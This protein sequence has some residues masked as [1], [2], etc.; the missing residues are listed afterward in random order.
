MQQSGEDVPKGSI[1]CFEPIDRPGII[2]EIRLILDDNR[3]I[4]DDNR[5]ILDDNRRIL[6]KN[7]SLRVELDDLTN[8]NQQQMSFSWFMD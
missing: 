8:A 5:R 1:A 6:D 7:Q 3:R 4:L 2:Q